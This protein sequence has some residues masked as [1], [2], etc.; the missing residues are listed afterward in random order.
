MAK[1]DRSRSW[2]FNI[3]ERF[4]LCL[5]VRELYL[6]GGFRALRWVVDAQLCLDCAPKYARVLFLYIYY[7]VCFC[8]DLTLALVVAR[9]KFG[10][11]L[12]TNIHLWRGRR[13]LL[14]LAPPTTRTLLL[15]IDIRLKTVIIVF[16]QSARLRAQILWLAQLAVKYT[17][18]LFHFCEQLSLG[19]FFFWVNLNFLDFDELFNARTESYWLGLCAR[20]IAFWSLGDVR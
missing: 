19:S 1:I 18:L 2:L 20:T 15:T 16:C 14:R 10:Q 4:S 6:L 7:I 3:I 12:W 8:L 9:V 13:M 17:N 5:E 11:L